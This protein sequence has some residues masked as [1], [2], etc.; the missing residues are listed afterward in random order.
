LVP[1]VTSLAM[2]EAAAPAGDG[3]ILNPPT[4]QPSSAPSVDSPPVRSV[5]P[6]TSSGPRSGDGGVRHSHRR[7]RSPWN[8]PSDLITLPIV[9]VVGALVT[10]AR[11]PEV[12]LHPGLWAEDGTVFFHGAYQ[13]NWH[14]PLTQSDGGYLQ[15][16][17]RLVADS[18]LLVSLRW[19]P[20]L[21]MLVALVVQVLPAVLLSSHRYAQ[22]VPDV[23][24][25]WLLA[26]LYLCVPNSSEVF[27][28]LTDAQ[29]HLALLAVLVVLALPAT[30]GWKVFDIA[31]MVLSGLSGPYVLS[32][33]VVLAL[34]LYRWRQRW[35]V[36][37]GAVA[38]VVGAVQFLELLTADR[39]THGPAGPTLAR[40]V[41]LLGGRL[42]GNTV[43]GT[44][45]SLSGGY[46]AHLYLY[47]ALL[48][49]VAVIIVGVAVWLGPFELK[50]FNLWA[51]LTLAGSLAS[52]LVS[53]T[54]SQWQGL[55]LDPG[56]RYWLFPSLALLVDAVWL[57][58]QVRTSRR[59]IGAVAVAF[60]VVVAAFGL[61]EDF[62]Y[63]AATSPNWKAEVAAFEK[64]P[65]GASYTFQL[66]PPGWT[67]VLTKK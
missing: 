23:R 37:L 45:T 4:E 24:V 64:L 1:A 49:A 26:A 53:P 34:V 3:S 6:T 54:G 18:G 59:W 55:I 8:G 44:G 2:T 16:F 62:R 13:T 66:R 67:M 50:M 65:P 15:T 48:L 33:I 63:P 19:V 39:G 52:P 58:G 10:L 28:N 20:T 11:A 40:L 32:L 38:L 46:L 36:V 41:E 14:A 43:L 12:L 30:G 61:R 7:A 25:R 42:V 5:E 35:T 17:S 22:A 29:W 57:V 31:V 51:G 9:F 56:G 47:S 60:L 21:F 27:V